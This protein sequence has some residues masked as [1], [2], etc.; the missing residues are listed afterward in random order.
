M[1]ELKSYIKF[2]PHHNYVAFFLT[3]G[4]NLSCPYC[5]NRHNRGLRVARLKHKYLTL[6]EWIDAANRLVLRS[7]LPLTLQGGEPTLYKDFYKFVNEVK[8]EIKMD[9]LTNMNFDVDKFIKE[10]PVERFT[11]QAPYAAIRVSYHPG[12]N[13][14]SDLIKKTLKMQDAGFRVGLYSVLIPDEKIR[15]HIQEV[16]QKC[17]DLGIDFR[18]KEFLGEYQ[19]ALYGTFKYPD[20]IC[21]RSLKYCRC[22]TTE[23]VVDPCGLV[24]RCHSDLYLAR[25]PVAHILDEDFTEKDIDKFRDC[26]FYGEC[27]PCDVKLKTNRFQI[28][29]HTSV[30]IKDVRGL[31]VNEKA[32]A[33]DG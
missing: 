9:L 24:Y 6:K 17:S 4:C 3:L 15:E 11:R 13:D 7:D 30:Q 1:E 23:L 8:Q 27:N 2:K 5:I 25:S 14:I 19:G 33:K 29:G 32:L 26:Y 28:F 18:T 31:S 22:K 20:S 12:Q 16:K 10:A 21:S